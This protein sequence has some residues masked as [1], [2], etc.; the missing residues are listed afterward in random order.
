MK[1]ETDMH[2]FRWWYKGM[3]PEGVKISFE[4]RIVARDWS[5]AMSTVEREM[6]ANWPG[7]RWM[8]GKEVETETVKLGP[9][10]QRLKTPVKRNA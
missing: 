9:T 8:Q 10:V 6:R 1:T 5:E 3:T 7:I 2:N 4:G